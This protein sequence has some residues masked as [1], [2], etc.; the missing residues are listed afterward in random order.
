MDFLSEAEMMKRLEHKNIVR[1]L[2]VC[3]RGEPVYAV[4]EFMLHGTGFVYLF[5]YFS[6]ITD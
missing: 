1:L 5:I 4:M 3:T 6:V 2:G